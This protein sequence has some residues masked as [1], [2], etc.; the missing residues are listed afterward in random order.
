M[1][2]I[3]RIGAS[4]S[5][6]FL[7]SF[8][9][10][11]QSTDFKA[12]KYIDL[13]HDVLRE[14]AVFYVDTVQIGTLVNEAIE[15]ML[16]QL[17]PYTELIPEEESESLEL[18]TTGSYGGVGSYIKGSPKG[19]VFSEPYENYPAAKAGIVPGDEILEIDGVST[20]GLS[21]DECSNA[22]KGKPNTEVRFK[23]KKVRTGEV[24]DLVLTRERIHFS[25]IT[26]YGMVGEGIGYIR[27][28]GFTMGG[29]NDLRRAF[30]ELKSGGGLSKLILDL[31]GNGGGLLEEAVNMLG[32]FLPRGTEVVSARGR[33]PQQNVFYKTKEE[34]IDVNIPI[35]L[36][37]NRGS[38]SSSEILAGAMQ[39]LDRGVI[40]GT[41][42]FGKGLVQS[43]RPLN[44]NAKLKI[45][46][47]KYYIPS[48]RCVQAIDYSHRN[49]DGSVGAIPDSLIKE[50]T[51]KNGR[52]V[53]DGGGITPDEKI[54]IG[55]YSR[56]AIELISRGLIWDYMVQYTLKHDQ[57]VTPELFALTDDE[58]NDFI[59]FMEQ[60]EFDG[61]SATEVMME[62]LLTM[63]KREGYDSLVVQQL[64][65]IKKITTGDR[66]KD[67]LRHKTE[68][69]R[70]LEE[71]ICA[72]YYYQKG[73]IRSMLRND[74]QLN[75]AIE[76]LSDCQEYSNILSQNDKK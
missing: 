44:Y 19:V 24:V 10:N 73:R 14:V 35:V 45:T 41:R 59:T 68:V 55:G 18:M 1:R 15:S 75:R 60:Q 23:I 7:L 32:M 63:A 43:I 72:T 11:A 51:T 49:E 42:T 64:N 5:A 56:M 69:K 16:E 34:P 31:R 30:L 36:L 22:M 52:S 40:I 65:D 3:F 27:I 6:L 29:G 48:G 54:E 26:Y 39:D 38:A 50:F 17:D 8:G 76:I 33:Y 46:M 67:L 70:L 13:F 47:A 4:F 53:F 62:Q 58:Y 66:S 12:G 9:L 21:T 61:R 28:A 71:E 74:I 57:I 37:V 25:D 20:A 2:K